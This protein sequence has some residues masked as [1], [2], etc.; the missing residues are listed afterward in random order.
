MHTQEIR[1]DLGLFFGLDSSNKRA[2][3]LVT[4]LVERFAG[5]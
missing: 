3:G 2:V 5:L 4:V 1:F